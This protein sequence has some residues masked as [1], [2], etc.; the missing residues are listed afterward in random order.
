[1]EIDVV[2]DWVIVVYGGVGVI[3]TLIVLALIVILYRK[4]SAILDS[5]KNTVDNIRRTSS[6]LHDNVIQPIARFHG[7]VSGI[8]R[9]MEGMS[10]ASKRGGEK[11]GAE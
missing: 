1:M 5:T 4:V 11:D 2:R 3:V 10:G 6:V 9:G 7:F 8:R